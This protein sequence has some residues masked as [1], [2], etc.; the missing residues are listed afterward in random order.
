MKKRKTTKKTKKSVNEIRDDRLDIKESD[1][2]ILVVED[3]QDFAKLLFDMTREKGFKCLMAGDGE[4]GLQLAMQYIPSAIILDVGLPRVDGWTVMERLKNNPETRH[5]PVYFISGQD[6]KLEAMQM[7]AI[8]YLTKPVNLEELN[9][10]FSKIEVTI[11]K[12]IKKLLVVEDDENMRNSILELIGD[13]DVSITAT[14]KGEEALKLIRKD[15]FDCVVLD[16]GL[17]DISGFDLLEKINEDNKISD[18]PIIIYTGKELTKKEDSALQKYAQSIIIK[19]AKSPDRLL[20]EV[21]LFLHRV[22]SNL[23]DDKKSQVQI[24]YDREEIFKGKRVLIVDDDIRNIYAVSSILGDKDMVIITAENGRDALD[25]LQKDPKVDLILMDI[26]MPEMDGYEAIGK[27]RQQKEFKNVPIIALTAKAMKG[28][29]QKCI[30]AGANDY[31]SKPVDVDKLLS[32]L[33][34][35]LYK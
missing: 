2:T 5:I 26:M 21:S 12:D 16:L 6:K 35:W 20:D 30:D 31:L 13:N 11:S 23:P 19:G 27:I 8:G 3:D 29:R 10:A 15:D 33:R 18:I 22:E 25:A 32:L 4:A 24:Q 7:G 17:S 34:V 1:K 9:S 28:D 14:G